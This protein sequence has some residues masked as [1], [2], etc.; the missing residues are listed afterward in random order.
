MLKPGFLLIVSCLCVVNCVP[1]STRQESEET[2]HVKAVLD[3]AVVN[4]ILEFA[5]YFG[6]INDF[7]IVQH[8]ERVSDAL[9]YYL[10]KD[11]PYD[12]I[13]YSLLNPLQINKLVCGPWTMFDGNGNPTVSLD[14]CLAGLVLAKVALAAPLLRSSLQEGGLFNVLDTIALTLDRLDFAEGPKLREGG[15]FNILDAISNNIDRIDLSGSGPE[16][17]PFEPQVKE[18]NP[19]IK[20]IGGVE[21]EVVSTVLK[22]Q[23][24]EA[25]AKKQNVE[26]SQEQKQ[27]SQSPEDIYQ[28]FGFNNWS[29]GLKKITELGQMLTSRQGLA[30]DFPEWSEGSNDMEL[31]DYLPRSMPGLP[32]ARLQELMRSTLEGLRAAMSVEYKQ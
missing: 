19:E 25:A 12:Q 28:G 3:H 10:T 31:Y 7:E 20:E 23:E 29:S 9:N 13:I 17:E 22:N 11:I 27:T 21:Y 6:Y 4:R 8:I 14:V 1:L 15:I 2:R 30:S 32:T 16:G 18:N 5:S 26:S 24:K